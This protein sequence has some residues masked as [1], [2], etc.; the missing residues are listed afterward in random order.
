[1]NAKTSQFICS[2]TVNHRRLWFLFRML[3]P[4]TSMGFTA[5]P[6]TCVF[7][8]RVCR[9]LLLSSE[10]IPKLCLISGAHFP[11]FPHADGGSTITFSCVNTTFP[12]R[13]FKGQ[14]KLLKLQFP[15][16]Q[17]AQL[18]HP[19]SKMSPPAPA[20]HTYTHT[21]IYTHL[22]RLLVIT[23]KFM[24]IN[25]ALI[26]QTLTCSFISQLVCID[27]SPVDAVH[28]PLPQSVRTQRAHTNP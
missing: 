2:I 15:L 10:N 13:S 14:N 1:M 21:G 5:A 25:F 26:C 22:N 11:L 12:L 23:M 6:A 9:C 3:L 19:E 20:F 17:N 4:H 18:L 28:T 16:M 8:E 27:L 24:E 7:S